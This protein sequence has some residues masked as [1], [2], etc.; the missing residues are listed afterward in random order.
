MCRYG[1]SAV[2]D[3]LWSCNEGYGVTAGER[4][5]FGNIA[6]G[7]HYDEHTCK[8]GNIAKG[9]MV[10]NRCLQGINP[11]SDANTCTVGT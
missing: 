10:W 8:D 1:S 11:N 4:C 2:G 7:W 6:E 9:G 3:V 5:K